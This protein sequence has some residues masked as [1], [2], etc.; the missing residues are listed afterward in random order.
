MSASL[1]ASDLA[2]TLAENP[3]EG[4]PF[5]GPPADEETVRAV[6]HAEAV[7]VMTG[8]LADA[9]HHLDIAATCCHYAAGGI[10]RALAPALRSRAGTRPSVSVIPGGVRR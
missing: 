7:P 4:A 9:A 1:A 2:S 10:T 6:R 5:P 3:Y 8:H